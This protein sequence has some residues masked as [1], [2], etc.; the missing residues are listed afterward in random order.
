MPKLYFYYG[1]MNAGKSM[2]LLQAENN[3]RERGLKTEPFI[4]EIIGED[5]IKSRAGISKKATV[6]SGDF[7]FVEYFEGS[8]INS[9]KYMT[10]CIFI[11]EAQFLTKE[12]V[13]QLGHIVDVLEIPV[14]CYGLRSDFKGEPFE[15][16][17]YLLVQADELKEIKTICSC[18]KKAIMNARKQSEENFALEGDQ[19]EIGHNK[20]ISYCRMCFNAIVFKNTQK[21]M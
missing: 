15:G 5:S 2:H 20:Y 9:K 13:V 11:D 14:M 6:F 12:Q 10:D 3:Y 8:N 16:S 19:I 17:S 1:A 4:P 21:F 7:N 18:G